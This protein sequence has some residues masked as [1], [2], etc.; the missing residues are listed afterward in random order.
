MFTGGENL[1]VTDEKREFELT[2]LLIFPPLMF[3]GVWGESGG[4]GEKREFE[5]TFLLFFFLSY[6]YR[7]MGTI[8]W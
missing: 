4:D 6:V 8:W 3:T 2:F 1:V 7:C 5:L